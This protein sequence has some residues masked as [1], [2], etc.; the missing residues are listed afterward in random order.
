MTKPVPAAILALMGLCLAAAIQPSRAALLQTFNFETGDLSQLNSIELDGPTASVTA[1]T[2]V[3]R[4]GAYC[5]KSTIATADKRA[6]GVSTL[7]GTVG[8][9]NWYGWSIYAPANYPGDGLYDIVSQFHDW[10]STQPA[11]GK[12]NKA[13]TCFLFVNGILQLDLKYQSAPQTVAHKSFNL[14]PTTKGAWHDIVVNVKWTHLSDGFMKVWVNGVQKL[15]YTGPTYMDYGAANGPYFKMGNYKGAYNWPGTSPRVFY[16]DEFRMGDANSSFAEVNPQPVNGTGASEAENLPYTASGASAAVIVDA[17]SSGGKWVKLSGDSTGD[18]V[19]FTV[20]VT[21][22][23]R[24]ISIKYKTD[25]TRGKLRLRIVEN[26]G[27]VGGELDQ[28]DSG[29]LYKNAYIGSMTFTTTGN[30]TFRFEVSGKNA[31]STGY[32]LSIDSI[33]VQ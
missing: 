22:G 21:A 9:A 16:M 2:T 14:G 11:W 28:Y 7:R 32:S 5:M 4:K 30:K 3:A 31:A 25:D 19:Q 26:N 10:H 12:D 6:E 29:N 17:Q 1:S 13:P 27:L 18:Y 8:G 33:T 23:T 24:S 20:P 15:N